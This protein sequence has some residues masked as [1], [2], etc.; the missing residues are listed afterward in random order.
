MYR[1]GVP[2]LY[3]RARYHP[4]DQ[5]ATS[6][7][8]AGP[9]CHLCTTRGTSKTALGPPAG[10]RNMGYSGLREEGGIW[11]IP[12]CGTFVTFVA[13]AQSRND[14]ECHLLS[15]S[16]GIVGQAVGSRAGI[17]V[18]IRRALDLDVVAQ[19]RTLAV[20]TRILLRRGTSL[21][22]TL[23]ALSLYILSYTARAGDQ[24]ILFRPKD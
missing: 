3:Y 10:S 8:P 4:R 6:V 24:S 15:L 9:G 22:T 13:F 23:R 1:G 7:P 20:Q 19:S 12:G 17:T 14:Q 18:A 2:R 11:I 16:D 5:V 21:A